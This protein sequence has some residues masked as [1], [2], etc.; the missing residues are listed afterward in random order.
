MK[1][2]LAL[3]ATL[4][5]SAVGLSAAEPTP[6]AKPPLRVG[7]SPVFPPMVF[8]QGK[9]LVGVEVELARALGEFGAVA[10]V[11]GKISGKTETL[12]THVEERFQ[13]FDLVGA[14]T[15]SIVLAIMALVV[16]M[17]MT[18]YQSGRF[19]RRGSHGHQRPLADEAVR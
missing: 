3:I 14:Y 2:T 19:R 7:V 5:L 11:S 16:L 17:T 4:A 9:E 18:I 12:T 15:A 1:F 10:I 13:A 6:A 8:K